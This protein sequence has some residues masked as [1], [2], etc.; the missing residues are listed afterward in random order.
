[1]CASLIPALIDCVL[2]GYNKGTITQ[3]KEMLFAMWSFLAKAA[4]EGLKT[5]TDVTVTDCLITSLSLVIK[6]LGKG[7]LNE[8]LMTL[9]YSELSH[10]F[11]DWIV[12]YRDTNRGNLLF[13]ED[14]DEETHP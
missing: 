7:C 8:E 6:S 5:E 1:M 4:I 9:I 12:R 2:A 14:E 11:S 3:P 13:D 10:Q